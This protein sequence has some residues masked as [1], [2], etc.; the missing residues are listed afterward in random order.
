[1]RQT[2]WFTSVVNR[3]S[4]YLVH[5]SSG[6]DV[7][8][9]GSLRYVFKRKRGVSHISFLMKF[10]RHPSSVS[11]INNVFLYSSSR[12]TFHKRTESN[13]LKVM[14]RKFRVMVHF[15]RTYR[16]SAPGSS[17]FRPLWLPCIIDIICSSFLC[18]CRSASFTLHCNDIRS[19]TSLIITVAWRPAVRTDTW[20][21]ERPFTSTTFNGFA[22]DFYIF[23]TRPAADGTDTLIPIMFLITL[24]SAQTASAAV[25]AVIPECTHYF[26]EIFPLLSLKYIHKSRARHADYLCI[27]GMKKEL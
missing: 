22:A 14:S 4:D 7:R 10:W 13:E 21:A 8:L 6:P 2:S 25:P 18:I 26:H 1:M 3:A 17:D 23:M 5:I 9:H 16:K 20:I 11:L 19:L 15:L 24:F 27:C 12:S